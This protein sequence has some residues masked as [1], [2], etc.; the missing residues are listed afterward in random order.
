MMA[1]GCRAMLNDATCCFCA[2]SATSGQRSSEMTSSDPPSPSLPALPPHGAGR[3][4]RRRGGIDGS[5][6]ATNQ[7]HRFIKPNKL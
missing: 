1:D 3:I 5:Y 4:G 7:I 6:P 2:L